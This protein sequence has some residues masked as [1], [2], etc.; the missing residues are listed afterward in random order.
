[1]ALASPHGPLRRPAC[2]QP[3][4]AVVAAA[5]AAVPVGSQ[6]DAQLVRLEQGAL[7]AADDQP[8][9]NEDVAAAADGFGFWGRRVLVVGVGA[10]SATD[11]TQD[12]SLGARQV[13]QTIRRGVGLLPWFLGGRPNAQ[14]FERN[15]WDYVPSA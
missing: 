3:W 11:I 6:Q 13:F 10:A 7:K 14:Y 5:A 1:M 15:S 8:S 4:L 2:T 12:L 9:A